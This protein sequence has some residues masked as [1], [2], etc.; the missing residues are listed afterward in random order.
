MVNIGD[1]VLIRPRGVIALTVVEL[2]TDEKGR[3]AAKVAI[4]ETKLGVPLSKLT[5]V[6]EVEQWLK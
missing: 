4:G 2:Y 3:E 5:V 6:K 1:R